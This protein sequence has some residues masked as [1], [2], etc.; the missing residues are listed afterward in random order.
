MQIKDRDVVVP[1]EILTDSMEYL[2]SKGT[3][4]DNNKIYAK[5]VGLVH[6][7]RKVIKLIPLSGVYSPKANDV[8]IGEV[9]DQ[10]MS[11]W[12]I[13]TNSPYSAMLS[14]KDLS[15]HYSR[16]SENEHYFRIGDYAIVKVVNVTP[17]KLVD[18]SMKGPGLK[19]I[20]GGRI[21]HVSPHKVPRIIGKAGNM[22]SLIKQ[23]TKSQIVV[24]QNGVIWISNDE[25]ENELLAVKV[26]NKIAHNSHVKGLTDIIKSD[27]GLR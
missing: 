3:Y 18:V 4:R 13:E 19:K 23:G 21:I 10:F 5:T 7:D 15:S 11:G 12:K 17:Q 14:Y 8:I 26:I 22:V 20:N 6:V 2:P 1:G 25:P 16:R 9:T 24:G 27:L